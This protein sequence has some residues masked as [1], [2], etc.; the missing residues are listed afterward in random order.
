MATDNIVSLH[1]QR[2]AKTQAERAKA[3]RDRER[4][5]KQAKKSERKL[6]TDDPLV[7]Q[8]LASQDVPRQV[9]IEAGAAPAAADVLAG[10]AP[11][12]RR[13]ALVPALRTDVVPQ[14]SNLQV[15]E[16]SHGVTVADASRAVTSRVTRVTF[17]PSSIA[18]RGAA[19]ALAGVG[20]TMNGWFARSLGSTDI[21]GWLFLAVG[22][23]AD[24]A[25]LALP[26][27]AVRRWHAS[28]RVSAVVA[29]A[30]WSATLAFALLSSIGFASL[31]ISDVTASRASR[32]T[33]AV[34]VA[35]AQLAD[36]QVARDREC[37]TGTGKFCREREAA[38]VERTQALNAALGVVAQQADP[39][40]EAAIK[41][42]AFVTGGHLHPTSDDL[43]LVRLLLLAFLP[44]IGGILLMLAR[45]R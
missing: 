20:I 37:K 13:Q 35:Q 38:V 39:Q 44:Q 8:A 5:K 19:I 17:C 14:L 42:V 31:N 24:A 9:H 25:A 34:T 7:V 27:T 10:S 28:Q 2:K 30:F 4:A 23:A 1:L 45:A 6:G 40:T 22:V 26:S 12:P 16:L 21:A 18:L 33:P 32:V 36:A 41:V 29:W 43:A 11:R 3:Y 15:S